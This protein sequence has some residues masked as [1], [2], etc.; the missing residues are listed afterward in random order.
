MLRVFQSMH[1]FCNSTREA[2]HASFRWCN[3]AKSL[4]VSS[5]VVVTSAGIGLRQPPGKMF[6]FWSTILTVSKQLPF[7]VYLCPLEKGKPLEHQACQLASS[8]KIFLKKLVLFIYCIEGKGN[9][10]LQENGKQF[11]KK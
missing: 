3:T 8:K 5:G 7:L 1:F 10:N 4:R 2:G 11:L 6:S 9:E